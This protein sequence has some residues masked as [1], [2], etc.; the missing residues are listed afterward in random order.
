MPRIV[1]Q[2]WNA[3]AVEILPKIPSAVRRAKSITDW[4]RQSA[5]FRRTLKISNARERRI[6]MSNNPKQSWSEWSDKNGPAIEAIQAPSGRPAREERG[7]LARW[8][9]RLVRLVAPWYVALAVFGESQSYAT[10]GLVLALA[11]LLNSP[12]GRS[13][14]RDVRQE[15]GSVGTSGVPSYYVPPSRLLPRPHLCW[16][17]RDFHGRCF[18]C[19]SHEPNRRGSATPERSVGVGC[20]RLLGAR[21]RT[22]PEK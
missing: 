20:G 12:L 3:P 5:T 15:T 18:V 21:G 4:K 6:Q 7:K 1:R 13:S 16:Q 9:W 19:G 22:P 17:H 10:A 2:S 11:W 14:T 8:L